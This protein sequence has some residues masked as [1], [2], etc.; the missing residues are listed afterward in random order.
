[1]SELFAKLDQLDRRI[2]YWILIITLTATLLVPL[3]LPVSIKNS[4]RDLYEGIIEVQ[5]GEIVHI[6]YHMS[7]STWPECLDGLIVELKVFTQNK[8]KL[9]LTSISVDCEMTWNKINDMVPALNTEYEYGEDIVFL[10]YFPGREDVVQQ[11]GVDMW[12]VFPTD[13]FG[14][15]VEDLPLMQN[16]KKATDF[17]M[18][19]TTGEFEVVWVNQWWVPYKVPVGVMGIAMKGSALQPYYASGDLFGL[20]VGVRGGAELELLIGEPGGAAKKMDSISLSHLLIVILI[21]LANIGFLAA[22]YSGGR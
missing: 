6:N 16:A 8:V 21:I 13:H 17:A 20:A 3:G 14:T 4:T 22:K 11:M 10:G 18:V 1:M 5:P 9:V 19:L 12:S 15:P 7:V 2:Y